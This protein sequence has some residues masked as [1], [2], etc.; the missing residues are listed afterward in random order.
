MKDTSLSEGDE[1]DGDDGGTTT[2]PTPP[3]TEGPNSTQPQIGVEPE[4]VQ[5]EN[6]TVGEP[7]IRSIVVRNLVTSNSTLVIKETTITGRHPSEFAAVND[8]DAP[9]TLPLG[10]RREIYIRFTPRTTDERQ[11][12]LQIVSNVRVSHTDVWLSKTGAYLVV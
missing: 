3:T 7:Q 5:F 6:G 4:R 9:F 8:S 10:E 12:Q 2:T 1:S 11:A